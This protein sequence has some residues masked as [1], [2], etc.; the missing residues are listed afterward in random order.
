M[1]S[2]A[3]F[4]KPVVKRFF[5]RLEASRALGL[6]LSGWRKLERRRLVVPVPLAT[7]TAQG[8]KAPVS[9]GRHPTVVICAEDVARLR[10][11]EHAKRATDGQLAAAAFELYLAGRSVVEVVIALKLPP[12]RARALH[13]EFT[14][15]RGYLVLPGTV[16][17]ELRHLGFAVTQ[18]SFVGVVDRLVQSVREGR[19]ARRSA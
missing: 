3:T 1:A 6:S 10:E 2:S 12:E 9:G 19:R 15:S 11:S 4:S 8:Y 13:G 18:E 7:A 17:D 14:A 5:T 16:L